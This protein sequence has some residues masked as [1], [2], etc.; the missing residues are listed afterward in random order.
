[1]DEGFEATLRRDTRHEFEDDDLRSA[2]VILE[3]VEP[4]DDGARVARRNG[5]P[6]RAPPRGDHDSW[7]EPS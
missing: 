6:H 2:V 3:I 7:V 4:I 1:M 5:A